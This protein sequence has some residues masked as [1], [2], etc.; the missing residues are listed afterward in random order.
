MEAQ[1][2]EYS[3][4]EEVY[5]KNLPAWPAFDIYVKNVNGLMPAAM[6]EN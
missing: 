3:E 6:L 5:Y 2:E 1:Q 4:R